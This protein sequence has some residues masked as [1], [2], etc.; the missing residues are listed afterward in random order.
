MPRT[1]NAYCFEKFETYRTFYTFFKHIFLRFRKLDV[2]IQVGNAIWNVFEIHL[3]ILYILHILVE[4]KK[5]SS[6]AWCTARHLIS[7]S[8]RLFINCYNGVNNTNI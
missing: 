6:N 8:Y 3:S 1:L 4:G 7:F 5:K 2:Y